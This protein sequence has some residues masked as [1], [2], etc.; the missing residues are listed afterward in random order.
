MKNGI[1]RQGFVFNSVSGLRFEVPKGV[2]VVATN[3]R[4]YFIVQ[5]GKPTDQPISVFRVGRQYFVDLYGT[6]H[7]LEPFNPHA[8]YPVS[9]L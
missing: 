1:L 7:M 8:P 3:G 9:L 5:Q 4:V 2:V 6:V